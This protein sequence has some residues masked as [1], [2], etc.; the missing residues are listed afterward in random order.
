MDTGHLRTDEV[1]LGPR[2]VVEAGDAVETTMAW[3]WSP[4]QAPSAEP[5]GVPD[6]PG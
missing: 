5:G 6:S 1:N 4:V 3:R 2:A